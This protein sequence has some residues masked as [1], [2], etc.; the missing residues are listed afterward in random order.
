MLTSIGTKE[1]DCGLLKTYPYDMLPTSMIILKI[2][3]IIIIM[4]K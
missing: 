4:I 2:I 1:Y 3:I